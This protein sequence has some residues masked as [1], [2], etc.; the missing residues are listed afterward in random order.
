MRTRF[1]PA[2]TGLTLGFSRAISLTGEPDNLARIL[3]KDI[4][5]TGP[6]RPGMAGPGLRLRG[7]PRQSLLPLRGPLPAGHYPSSCRHWA[8]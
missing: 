5:V 2:P 6:G 7:N 1:D 4:E 3:N 8:G